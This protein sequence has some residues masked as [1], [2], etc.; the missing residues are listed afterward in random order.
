[1]NYTPEERKRIAEHIGGLV[2]AL[3][4]EIPPGDEVDEMV[5]DELI[6]RG[7][8]KGFLKRFKIYDG[9]VE[10]MYLGYYQSCRKGEKNE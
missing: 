8:I 3:A 1:M 7:K 2:K 5:N 9:E 6:V 4:K 10:D